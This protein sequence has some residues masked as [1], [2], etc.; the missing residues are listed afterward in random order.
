MIRQDQVTVR[1]VVETDKRNMPGVF[2]VMITKVLTG[3]EKEWKT[4]VKTLTEIFKKQ[5]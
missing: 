5:R 3:L 1:D 4:S 2:K